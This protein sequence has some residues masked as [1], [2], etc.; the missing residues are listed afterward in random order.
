ASGEKVCVRIVAYPEGREPE[1][2]IER[3]IGR[4]GELT[5]E[6]DAI[7]CAHDL[8]EEFPPKVLA[9][10]ARAAKQPISADGRRDFRG[11]LVI[12]I[13]GEDSRD[14]DDAIS[15]EKRGGQFLLC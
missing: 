4:N 5:T 12:T 3:V 14:F 9:A 15:V 8:P 10:A 6:E 1:G 2:E 11:D 13:D 7:V